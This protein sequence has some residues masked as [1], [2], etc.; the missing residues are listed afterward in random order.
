MNPENENIL[1]VPIQINGGNILPIS[2]GQN[3][4]TE[5][6]ERELYVC[7]NTANGTLDGKLYVGT[8][9]GKEPI[10]VKV[11]TAEKAETIGGYNY[12]FYLTTNSE[13]SQ[14]RIA[15]FK[16]DENGFIGESDSTGDGKTPTISTL[17]LSDLKKLK[18]DIN[19]PNICGT[20]LPSGGEVGQIFFKI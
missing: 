16:F 2:D 12:P 14:L 10:P 1:Y 18:I 4:F 19:N 9:A 20:A 17:N 8:G 6:K 11:E 3:S 13:N 15:G 5:L 7:L